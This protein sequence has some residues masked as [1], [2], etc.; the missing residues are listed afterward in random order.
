ME[1]RKNGGD[2]LH[3]AHAQ[4]NVQQVAKAAH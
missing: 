4:V 2:G 3:A 1:V